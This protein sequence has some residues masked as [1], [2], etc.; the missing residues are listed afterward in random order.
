MAKAIQKAE[1]KL[2]AYIKDTGG[3]GSENVGSDDIQLPRISVLQALSHEIKESDAKY[4]EGAKQG[5][6][7]NALTEELYP[8]GLKFVPVYFHKQHLVWKDREAGGGLLG[9]FDDAAEAAECAGRN[10]SCEAVETPTHIVII[11]DDDGNPV[12]E[13]V[14]PMPRSKYKI[15]RKFNSLVQLHG[16]DR[17]SGMYHLS[18]IEDES[19]KG[20][21]WN[22]KVTRMGYPPEGAYHQAEALYET[23]R[24]GRVKVSA[25]YSDAESPE[26]F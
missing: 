11:C 18:S 12:S 7:Y 25:D 26:Q 17:F 13:A 24:D 5:Q 6:I 9:I 15:S 14:I 22:F 21:Y 23:I 19:P 20:E 16:G 4:I 1:E 2:P 8:D 3:R 10:D